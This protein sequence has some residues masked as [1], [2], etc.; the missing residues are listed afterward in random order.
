MFKKEIVAE[1]TK[2]SKKNSKKQKQNK[3]D[4][5]SQETQ[6]TPGRINAKKTKS[7]HILVILLKNKDKRKSCKQPENKRYIHRVTILLMTT[8]LKE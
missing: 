6:W 1:N 7:R 5:Q 4:L 8:G 3:T 2:F